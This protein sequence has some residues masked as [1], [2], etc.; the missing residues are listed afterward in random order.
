M[1]VVMAELIRVD[2]P[3]DPRLDDYRSLRDTSL[4]KSLESAHG[5]FIAE[6]EKVVRRSVEAGFEARS[7]LMAERWLEGLADELAQAGDVPCY[8]VSEADAETITGFHVHRGALASLRRRPLPKVADVLRHATRVVVLEDVM[9]HTNVGAILRSTAA[10]GAD[11]AL[12]S[13]RCA[14]PLYR[15]AIKVSMGAVFSLP[16]TRV[17]DWY[18]AIEV[19]AA[20]GFT[21]VALTLDGDAIDVAAPAGGGKTALIVGSEGPGMSERW[22]QSAD[23]R[24]RIP[25]AAGVDSLNVAAAAAVAAYALWVRPHV[26]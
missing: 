24:A 7:F 13:P 9:D 12:L 6:G 10:L 18:D 26:K 16:W 4:R 17:D 22:Q 11:A 3:A 19:L 5:L 21:T 23:V 2:D 1:M 8:V 14:D 20:A 25:M 15:R